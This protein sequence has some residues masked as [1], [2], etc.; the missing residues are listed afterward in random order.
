MT[1]TTG[2]RL[3]SGHCSDSI[4]FGTQPDSARKGGTMQ[5]TRH[6]AELLEDY[7]STIDLLQTSGL[8]IEQIQALDSQR[9]VLHDMIIEEVKRLGYAVTSREDA[10]WKARQLV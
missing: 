3:H 5:D 1:T 8:P 6:L 7:D 4:F 10:V 9:M 2:R